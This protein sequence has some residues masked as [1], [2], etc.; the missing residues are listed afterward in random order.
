VAIG[1]GRFAPSPTG[2]LH[3]GSLVAA[4]A[5]YLDAR[6][7]GDAWLLRL[8]DIDEARAV[9]G[10][11][12]RIFSA[13]KLCGFVWTEPV[14]VQS[15]NLQAYENALDLLQAQG[16]LF[17]CDCGRADYQGAYPGTCRHVGRLLPA[18]PRPKSGVAIRLNT[19][20][21]GTLRWQDGWQGWQQQP[22]ESEIGDFVIR[23]KDGF[24]AYQLAVVVDDGAQGI[25]RVVRG[26]DLLDNTP[27]QLFLQRL[28]GLPEPEYAHL[29]LVVEPDGTKLSKS[30]S[31]AAVA[32]LEP[33]TALRLA[34]KLL[35]QPEPPPIV[36]T[37][38]DLHAWAAAHWNPTALSGV[39][40]LHVPR[41]ELAGMV[42]L[43]LP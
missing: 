41:V 39:A 34:L 1:R 27:R 15:K 40:N 13:L 36:D 43:Q 10:A 9:P 16:R 14:L 19:N 38:H 30:R 17:V 31:S 2:D 29:P 32:E 24:H 20:N 42:N 5:S 6:H 28:L 25:T 35:R 11:A 33:T 12:D 7:R 8:E 18:E 23:R 21:S 3:L 26:M 4:L 37:V 22:L